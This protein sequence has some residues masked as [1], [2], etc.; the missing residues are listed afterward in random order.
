MGRQRT[1]NDAEFW[2]APR[3]ADRTH[4]DKA[5]LL[6]LLTSPYSNIIG[7]YAIVPRI[8]AAEMGWTADQLLA[9]VKRLE[10]FG[11]VDYDSSSNFVWI[12]TWWDHNSAKMA[13]ASTLREKTYLQ[14]AAVPN[15]WRTE[16]LAD[17]LMRLPTGEKTSTATKDDLRSIVARDMA[18]RGYTVPIAYLQTTDSPAANTTNNANSNSYHYDENP[19]PL[20]YPMLEKS[21]QEQV[22]KIVSRLPLGMRQDVLDEIAAKMRAGTLRSPIRLAQHFA[23]NPHVFVI[24][25]GIAVRNARTQRLAVQEELEN[26]ALKRDD[27]LAD[28]D[29]QLRSMS[30]EQF[31][32]TYGRLPANIRQQVRDRWSKLRGGTST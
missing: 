28:I 5:T 15:S 18:S 25:E 20:E 24:S 9:I 8:A 10:S 14:I 1:I 31:E 19:A 4:E 2:R 7:V 3:I 23:D 12:R 13:V 17:F 30:E 29:A 26:Q 22:S 21:V 11:L 16:F 27:E 32:K 6:Y